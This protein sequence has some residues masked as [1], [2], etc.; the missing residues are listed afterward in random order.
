MTVGA[1]GG[2]KDL[3]PFV[4]LRPFRR[5]DASRFFART[6]ESAEVEALW[7]ANRVTVLCGPPGVGKTSLLEAGL[8]PRPGFATTD[9]LP[10]GRLS[11]VSAFPIAALP[12]HNPYT[13][14]L[15]TAWSPG[16]PATRLS[17]LTVREFLRQR[18]YRTDSYGGPKPIFAAIDQAE[19][20]FLDLGRRDAYRQAFVD[21]LADALD[22]QPGLRL[23]LSIRSGYSEDLAR[24]HGDLGNPVIYTLG[25]LT[26]GAAVAAVQQPVRQFGTSFAPGV[27]EEL[28]S[29]LQASRSIA[30]AANSGAPLIAEDDIEPT[31]LQAV[32]AGFWAA[33]SRPIETITPDQL[34]RYGDTS[35]LLGD[36]CSR[37]VGA[38]A[39]EH[40]L[41]APE[42]R[43]WVQQ[44]FTTPLR[45][46]GMAYEGLTET[47][48][49]PNAI[50]RALEDWHLLKAVR[51]SNLRWYELQHECLVGPVL[52]PDKV[53]YTDSDAF[54]P[55]S[56]ADHLR[57]AE[58]AMADGDL[59]LAERQ[60]V[61]AV[62]A[63]KETDLRLRAE[64]ESL[65][66]NVEHAR[67][68][69]AKAE[70]RYRHAAALFEAL[71]DTSAVA[72][73]LA[74]IGQ[75]LLAQGRAAEAVEKLYA[76]IRRLP[77]DLTV[78][79]ELGQ[80]LWQQG[81]HAA[82]V[83]VLTGVLTVN[84]HALNALRARGEILADLG[85][86]E[87]ALRDLDRV[88]RPR[89]P[90]VQAA[91]ALALATLRRPGAADEEIGEALSE[92]PDNGQVLLYA[93]RVGELG[94]D[95]V[96]AAN[97]ARRAEVAENPA[98]TPHQLE[99]A[100][101]LQKLGEGVLGHGGNSAA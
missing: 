48:G 95:R 15:L 101:R 52:G 14:A 87:K 71:Q 75:T 58:A 57:T 7:R 35:R 38:V 33:L 30:I 92:A 49:Q 78:Q 24:Y 59:A 91:R 4:G 50:P 16:E 39:D 56:A 85:E 43:S 99:Q 10:V 82:A 81:Q 62:D 88:R 98:L 37:A 3:G 66:G 73:L 46:R 41:S 18:G 54:P 28:V 17:G 27:A 1:S 72:R 86:A 61:A 2:G 12:E 90:T 36:F 19:K 51:R 53:P 74:A 45:T 8:L 55:A 20:L 9:V 70:A 23:L 68:Q 100:R 11:R 97:L 29:N 64:A 69:P 47:A 31:L 63:T 76:A 44:T 5:E 79:T 67:G 80:A 89:W 96:M 25:P 13:L 21:E 42:L 40:G 65:L 26:P 32:C 77:N 6:A 83:A 94:G 60:A 22:D 93:A 34:H 84:G